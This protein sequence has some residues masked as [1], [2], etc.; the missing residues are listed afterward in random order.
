MSN[1]NIT[2]QLTVVPDAPPPLNVYPVLGKYSSLVHR[3]HG[4]GVILTYLKR[5]NMEEKFILLMSAL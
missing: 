5:R 3:T 1:A 4:I 2:A